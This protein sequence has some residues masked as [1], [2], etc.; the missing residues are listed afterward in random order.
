M[1]P[2]LVLGGAKLKGAEPDGDA[3]AMGD[4][5]GDGGKK[6]KKKKEKKQKGAA[7]SALGLEH[8]LFEEGSHRDSVMVC[9]CAAVRAASGSGYVGL[10]M[11]DAVCRGCR[12]IQRGTK[13]WPRVPPTRP[14][15]S[16]TAHRRLLLL[17]CVCIPS[18][19]TRTRC[20][21]S[22]GTRPSPPSW[23]GS[24]LL[25]RA[26]RTPQNHAERCWLRSFQLDSTAPLRSWTSVPAPSQ[27]A[28]HWTAM[29][30]QRRGTRTPRTPS[31]WL[32]APARCAASTLG[33]PAASHFGR[34]P[35][36]R[37]SVLRWRSR[38][39]SRSGA[40]FFC[41]A[42]RC[43]ACA[44]ARAC[45]LLPVPRAPGVRAD[46]W[47]VAAAYAGHWWDRQD[48]PGLGCRPSSSSASLRART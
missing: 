32:A 17:A 33:P 4:S 34:W 24:R 45:P 28:G 44:V 15:R 3:T 47:V 46:G 18:R 31:W 6:K 41:C 7:E 35:H 40:P 20:S 11:R 9:P 13:Y 36:T 27:L 19:T 25:A 43:T 26:L 14:S 48:S 42:S 8:V 21:A 23:C 1:E 10:H 16:G 22:P 29:P 30:R 37:R 12:G 5:D 38:P 2:E 39:P